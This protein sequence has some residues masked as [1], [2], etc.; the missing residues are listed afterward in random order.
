MAWLLTVIYSAVPLAYLCGI[1]P[2]SSWAIIGA[3]I[4]FLSVLVAVRGNVA[5]LVDH[6]RQ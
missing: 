2:Y 6:L 3:N 5:R 1:Y 4:F